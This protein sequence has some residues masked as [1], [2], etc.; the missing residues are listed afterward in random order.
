MRK[1]RARD[2]GILNTLFKMAEFHIQVFQFQSHLSEL[3]HFIDL[4][5]GEWP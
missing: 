5:I 1:P 3:G 2:P 4:M